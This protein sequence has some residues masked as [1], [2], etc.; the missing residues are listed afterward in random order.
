M[1]TVCQT[2]PFRPFLSLRPRVD[3]R[4]GRE[5]RDYNRRY[6]LLTEIQAALAGSPELD[7]PIEDVSILSRNW[8]LVETLMP[9]V[10]PDAFRQT[11]APA[12]GRGLHAVLGG[13]NLN[14]QTLTASDTRT[15]DSRP[16]VKAHA[17]PTE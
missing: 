16:E 17:A 3:F 6:A 14:F 2:Y 12:R 1:G 8:K 9:P 13:V 10:F 4:A 7:G 15:S 5:G 11:A